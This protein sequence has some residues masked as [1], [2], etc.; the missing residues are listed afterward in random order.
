MKLLNLIAAASL[1]VLTSCSG[2]AANT[3]QAEAQNFLDEYS[4]TYQDLDYEES[5]ASWDL[6]TH[7]VEG[8]TTATVRA[9][10]AGEATAKFVGST[11]V[12][13]R[14]RELLADPEGLTPLQ[15]RQLEVVLFRAGSNPQTVADLV[16]EKIKLDN[17]LIGILFGFDFQIDGKSVT[18]NEID[19]ILRE[20]R[21]LDKRLAAWTA[22]KEVGRPLKPGLA[23][24]R[25]LRNSTVQA[26]GYDDFFSYQV[27]EYGMTSDEMMTLMQQIAREAY[28]L[29][30]ELHTW[31]RYEL[32]D[33]YGAETVPDL[34][35]AH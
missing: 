26:L 7:I 28:P 23:R 4:K 20:E 34:I 2:D 8:D 13:D 19:R 32:A 21:D 11:E 3:G 17:E 15:I 31:A 1:L 16:T 18:A 12:I 10:A 30:R 33:R 24:I 27:S 6:N 9:S 29:Y 35:P 14:V 5:L 22:S 25:D